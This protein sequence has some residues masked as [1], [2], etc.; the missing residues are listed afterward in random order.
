M[1]PPGGEKKDFVS[2]VTVLDHYPVDRREKC[3]NSLRVSASSNQPRGPLRSYRSQK[4]YGK[5]QRD[6]EFCIGY[7][8]KF[9]KR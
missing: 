7:R 9:Q 4:N 3:C 1:H 2:V 8:S 5:V 6:S